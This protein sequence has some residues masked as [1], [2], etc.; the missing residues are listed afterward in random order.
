MNET[1]TMPAP[2]QALFLSRTH[3]VETIEQ[4]LMR[5]ATKLTSP[6]VAESVDDLIR[7]AGKRGD[8]WPALTLTVSIER[9]RKCPDAY[10]VTLKTSFRTSIGQETLGGVK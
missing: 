4:G 5:F 1:P 9:D 2:Q 6:G 7:G 10:F 8:E 3:R